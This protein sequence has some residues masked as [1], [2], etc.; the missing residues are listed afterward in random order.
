MRFYIPLSSLAVLAL[1]ASA[2]PVDPPSGY[3]AS[4]ST[5]NNLNCDTQSWSMQLIPKDVVGLCEDLS[6]PAISV[7]LNN[8]AEGCSVVFYPDFDCKGRPESV[9][10]IGCYKSDVIIQSTSVTCET[11][12]DGEDDN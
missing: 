6:H 9:S 12:D 8:L 2:T 10:E 1:R 11:V 3:S 7:D 4:Y 5:F